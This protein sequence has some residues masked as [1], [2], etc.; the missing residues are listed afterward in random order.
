MPGIVL[1]ALFRRH[2]GQPRGA[3]FGISLLGAEFSI[4][5]GFAGR[6]RAVRIL[7]DV[8]LSADRRL[9][10]V[11]IAPPV[12]HRRIAARLAVTLAG[13]GAARRSVELREVSLCAL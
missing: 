11:P 3:L 10:A 5:L 4:E 6:R 1:G 13:G 12:L 8:P 7:D 2:G 9:P